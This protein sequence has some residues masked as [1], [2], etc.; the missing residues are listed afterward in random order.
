MSQGKTY[1]SRSKPWC[2]SSNRSEQSCLAG[3]WRQDGTS[4]DTSS[5]PSDLPAGI[6]A[7]SI[8]A[9]GSGV[10]LTLT[11]VTWDEVSK[12]GDQLVHSDE[13]YNIWVKVTLVFP[14]HSIRERYTNAAHE[15]LGNPRIGC[16]G[17]GCTVQP[18]VASA[19]WV[20][21]TLVTP[22]VPSQS[23]R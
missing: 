10:Q 18:S 12:P 1:N 20:L 13:R 15:N 9:Q 19:V 22:F 14:L 21:S 4:R 3:S 6:P 7:H 23:P 2:K 17:T 11:N 5:V 8:R 16:R